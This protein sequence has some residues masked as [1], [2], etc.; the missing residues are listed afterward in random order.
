[1]ADLVIDDI[2]LRYGDH[3]ILKGVSATVPPG[4]VVALLGPSGSGKTTL[5]RAVAG[6]ETPYRGSIRIGNTIFFDAAKQLDLPAEARGLGRNV[7]PIDGSIGRGTD[8][9]GNCI[10]PRD[11]HATRSGVRLPFLPGASGDRLAPLLQGADGNP[12]WRSGNQM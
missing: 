9:G 1:M 3:E 12:L 6:L 5:L 7:E 11:D 8:G 2:A 10:S 4:K